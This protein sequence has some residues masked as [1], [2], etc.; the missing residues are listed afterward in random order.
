MV[1]KSPPNSLPV[2]G[3]AAGGSVAIS[4]GWLGQLM[5]FDRSKMAE[6]PRRAVQR[7]H[8]P[9]EVMLMCVRW[10]AGYPLE[11]SPDRGDDGRARGFR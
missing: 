5:K 6:A 2:R 3:R 10:Y 7:A 1:S 8:Y 4:A 11:L 9:F